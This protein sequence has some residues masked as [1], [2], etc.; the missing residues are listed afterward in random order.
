MHLVRLIYASTP[1]PA[2]TPEEISKIVEVSRENNRRDGVTGVL[3][4]DHRY[5][6][7][8]IEGPRDAINVLYNKLVTDDRHKN[9]V[10]LDYAPIFAREFPNWDMGCIRSAELDND[11]ILK[12]VYEGD[13]DPYV[14]SGEGARA[15]LQEV[16]RAGACVAG[17]GEAKS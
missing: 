9:L 10:I 6:L 13:F 2:C 14:M 17:N 12:Y 15:F 7:Q 5:F 16:A 3:C 11:I 1:T 4:H 8:W